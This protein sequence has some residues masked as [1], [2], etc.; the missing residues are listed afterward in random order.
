MSVSI[1]DGHFRR[2]MGEGEALPQVLLDGLITD[3]LPLR[4]HSRLWV[5]V[6]NRE[7]VVGDKLSRERENQFPWRSRRYINTYT[8]T[9]DV[10]KNIRRQLRNYSSII[11]S[12]QCQ[13]PSLQESLIWEGA[14][15]IQAAHNPVFQ[16]SQGTNGY[17]GTDPTSILLLLCWFLTQ[18]HMVMLQ[19]NKQ[20]N[21]KKKR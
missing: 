10:E 19:T 3:Y 12:V 9:L 13:F 17:Q 8:S 6:I 15:L 1:T 21:K 16:I 18:F 5:C 11:L 7:L 20:T 2:T 14:Y 4:D